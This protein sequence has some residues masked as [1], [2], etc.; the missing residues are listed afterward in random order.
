MDKCAFIFYFNGEQRKF[1]DRGAWE[2][3]YSSFYSLEEE[4]QE[5]AINNWMDIAVHEFFHIV[6]PLTIAS[7]EV[8]EFNFNETNLS[9]Y[10]WL[11]EGS[12]ECY[13]HHMQVRTGI[14]SSEQFIETLAEK[15]NYLRSYFNDSLSFTELSKESAGKWKDQYGN[16]YLKGALISAGL[17]L[18]LLKLADGRY[19][20]RNLTHDLGVRFGKDH[21]FKDDALFG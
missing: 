2:H 20:F 7:K 17:D 9:R 19:A 5:S 11:Y 18:Y 10:L 21:Y 8:K 3:S 4:P 15:I 1:I 6:T 12:T 14:K 16:V 13:A